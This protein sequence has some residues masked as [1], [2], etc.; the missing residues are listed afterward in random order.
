MR[1]PGCES[2]LRWGTPML[3]DVSSGRFIPIAEALGL[4]WEIG[5]WVIREACRQ[6]RVWLDAGHSGFTIAVNVSPQQL[7]RPGLDRVVGDALR[8]FRVP[9]DRL[10]IELTE[11]IGRA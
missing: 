11:T 9:G 10:E 3:G 5:S 6:A 4:M 2:L 8:E 7:R 1:R